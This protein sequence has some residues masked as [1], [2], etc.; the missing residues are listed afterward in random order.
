MSSPTEDQYSSSVDLE[1]DD[2]TETLGDSVP[3]TITDTQRRILVQQARSWRVSA[4]VVALAHGTYDKKP[5]SLIGLRFQFSFQPQPANR[6]SSA[7]LNI[8]FQPGDDD[9]EFPAV[10]CFAPEEIRADATDAL[11]KKNTRYGVSAS[12]GAGISPV[13]VDIGAD[14]GTEIAYVQEFRCDVIGEPWTSDE[15]YS[16]DC[17]VDNAV[18][19]HMN[20][21][22]LL[23]KGIPRELRICLDPYSRKRNRC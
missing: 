17:E 19:W 4:D 5:A 3:K 10:P 22:K 15:A 21:H 13:S 23:K 20:E 6:L 16:K 8:S 1:V 14:R 2:G 18:T 9:G 7:E 11:M 12:V